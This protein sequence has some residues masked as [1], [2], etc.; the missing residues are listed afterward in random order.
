MKISD[1]MSAQN[2]MLDAVMASREAGTGGSYAEI[3]MNGRR[4]ANAMQ[5]TQQGKD[6]VKEMK[7][8]VKQDEQSIEEGVEKALANKK[9]LEKTEAERIAKSQEAAAKNAPAPSSQGDTVEISDAGLEAAKNVTVAVSPPETA[10][11]QAPAVNQPTTAPESTPA[12]AST[13][14]Q[15]EKTDIR[16]G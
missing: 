10:V 1:S 7:I 12:P 8:H 13:T 5:Q 2:D 9:E 16:Q 14:L 6:A 3:S 4:T 15:G 11:P